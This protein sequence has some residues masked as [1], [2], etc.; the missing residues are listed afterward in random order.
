[1]PEITFMSPKTG[2]VKHYHGVQIDGETGWVV[3]YDS[4]GV[5]K[6][7]PSHRVA[8]IRYDPVEDDNR[9]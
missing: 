8:R 3:A 9:V 4:G 5:E 2:E 7:F 1:M 6:W